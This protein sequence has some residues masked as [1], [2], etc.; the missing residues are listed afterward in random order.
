MKKFVGVL[1]LAAIIDISPT[2]ANANQCEWH[3]SDR[4][5]SPTV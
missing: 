2:F 1:L 5:P 3:I 4:N